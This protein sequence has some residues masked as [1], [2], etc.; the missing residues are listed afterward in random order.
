MIPVLYRSTTCIYRGETPGCVGLPRTDIQLHSIGYFWSCF[1]FGSFW[2]LGFWLDLQCSCMSLVTARVYIAGLRKS[3][4]LHI[5]MQRE[6]DVLLC[7]RCTFVHEGM[8]KTYLSLSRAL[9]F[10][11]FQDPHFLYPSSSSGGIFPLSLPQAVPEI[12]NTR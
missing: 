5:C 12:Q 8:Y 2:L 9:L 10:L 11:L 7:C 1:L 3:M 4:G 6:R